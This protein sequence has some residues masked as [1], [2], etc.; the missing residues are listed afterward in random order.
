MNNSKNKILIVGKGEFGTALEQVLSKNGNNQVTLWG[1]SPDL[2]LAEVVFMAVPTFAVSD[3]AQ[4]VKDT[5]DKG[6]V[7]VV[8][9]KGLGG[10]G[11]TPWELAEKVWTGPQVLISGPMIAEELTASQPGWAMTAGTSGS[12]VSK[13]ISFFKK[14]NLNLQKFG[15]LIGLSWSGPLKNLYAL[16]LGMADG[17]GKGLNYKGWYVQQAVGEMA[18]ITA[19][20]GGRKSTAYSIAGLGDLVATGF[21]PN[22]SNFQ[23]GKHLAEGKKIA[24]ISEGVTVAK[25]IDQRLLVDDKSI[26]LGC[27]IINFVSNYE[28]TKS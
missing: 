11:E 13:I 5:Q 7:L 14:T 16:G 4:K 25:G 23:L 10:K 20:F 28:F 9:S 17:R 27:K 26:K 21:S 2:P 6:T 22:S 3:V 1:K 12:A 19:H 24:K 18:E 8:L 15:D